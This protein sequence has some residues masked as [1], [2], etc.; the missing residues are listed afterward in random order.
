MFELE[1]QEYKKQK[2]EWSYIDFGLDLQ[3]TIDLIEKS[4]VN[5]TI[6]IPKQVTHLYVIQP[7]GILSCLE[8]ECVLPKGSDKRFLEKLNEVWAG[9]SDQ[10]S[11]GSTKYKPVR[12][13]EGFVVKHYAGNVEYSTNGWIDKNKDPLNEDITRLLARST[14]SHVASLFDEYLT[15]NEMIPGTPTSL[16]TPTKDTLL[17]LRKGTG[18]FQTVGQ[19]HKQ[20]L[21]SLMRTLDETHPHFVRCM[22]PNNRKRS[23]EIQPKLVLDQ[24]RCN[25]VLEGI[26]ICRKGFP[27]RLS[28][29]EFRKRYEL[30]CPNLKMDGHTYGRA[31]CQALLEAMQVDPERYRLGTSKV[32]FKATVVR[33]YIFLCISMMMMIHTRINF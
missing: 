5:I 4:K 7:R 25:G 13:K 22:L 10:Q 9:N 14:V 31:A 1:Q 26:R 20:Q 33:Y 29:D 24:L 2:I 19:R 3:P 21:L 17:K 18:S 30:L 16:D 8:E 27:N 32:F 6:D 12:F 15:D 28:F 11:N 23:G